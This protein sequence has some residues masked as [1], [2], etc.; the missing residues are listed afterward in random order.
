M[1]AKLT[2]N[3]YGKSRV[4]LTKV[5]R[6]P[7]TARH[8]ICEMSVDIT[9]QGDFA[10]SYTHGDN[11][12]IIATDSQK[13]TVYVLA[14]EHDFQ[15]IDQFARILADHFVTSY[16]QVSAADIAVQQTLLD[17]IEI[18]GQ[19]HDHAFVGGQQERRTARCFREADAEPRGWG[20]V[21]GLILLKTAGSE[22]TG[23]VDDRFRTLPDATQRI[24]ATTVDATWRFNSP[25][26][27]AEACYAAVRPTLIRCFAQHHSLAVQQTLLAMG[28]AALEASDAI[29]RVDLSLPNQH[30]IPFN[31]EPFGLE[32]HAEIFVPTD[33][34]AGQIRGTVERS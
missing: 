13:N 11:T 33:E 25:D 22:F 29:D 5:V 8:Q 24:F 15:T 23:F 34:P 32:N 30:R 3:A 17:R 31:L 27:D 21:A 28:Q 4:R 26:A 10:R 9:L 2:A 16:P 6:D 18:D 14:R 12:Q 1:T 20:G 7:D 19:P